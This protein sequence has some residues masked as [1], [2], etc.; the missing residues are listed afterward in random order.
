VL[1]PSYDS[2][3]PAQFMILSNVKTLLG[4]AHER[5]TGRVMHLH[6]ALGTKYGHLH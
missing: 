1:P 2:I 6:D 5:V 3:A 4:E